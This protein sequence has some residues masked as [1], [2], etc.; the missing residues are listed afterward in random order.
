[1]RGHY[2]S[3]TNFILLGISVAL[4]VVGFVLLGQGPIYNHLSWSVAPAIL[5]LV[6]CVLFPITIMYREKESEDKKEKK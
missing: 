1:M 4:L 2:F 5:V 6:Y 3:S